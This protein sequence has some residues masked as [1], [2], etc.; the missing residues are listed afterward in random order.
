MSSWAG[1]GSA[2][3]QR[4]AATSPDKLANTSEDRSQDVRAAIDD[5]FAQLDIVQ[6]VIA[7]RVLADRGVDLDAGRRGPVPNQAEEP[8]EPGELDS[9]SGAGSN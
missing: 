3:R 7:K 8:G 1:S 4:P 2:V 5:A 9:G 6:R